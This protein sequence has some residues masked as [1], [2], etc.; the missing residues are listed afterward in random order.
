[1]EKG[2]DSLGF[3]GHSYMHFSN[4]VCVSPEITEEYKVEIKRLKKKYEGQMLLYRYSMS[5]IFQVPLDKVTVEL[6]HLYQE[7]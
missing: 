5:K 6:Y 3:S 4:F 7:E 2:F 1:M